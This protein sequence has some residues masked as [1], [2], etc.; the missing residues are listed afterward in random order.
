KVTYLRSTNFSSQG[1]RTEDALVTTEINVPSDLAIGSYNLQVIAN[2]IASDPSP[3]HVRSQDCF[4]QFDRSTYAQG[5][6]QSMINDNGAPPALIAPAAFVIVEGFTPAELGLNAGNL[7]NPPHKPRIQD[8]TA[9]VHFVFSG[10]VLPED[11][12][13]PNSPQRFTFPF[14]AVFD[15]GD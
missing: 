8:P 10:P 13:L 9:G 2:A 4:L 12:A 11:P 3:V 5:E 15:N 6:I 7:G 14:K 1:V